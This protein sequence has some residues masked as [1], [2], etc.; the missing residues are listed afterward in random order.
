[1]VQMLL[2]V[3]DT[4]CLVSYFCEVLFAIGTILCLIKC[5]ENANYMFITAVKNSSLASEY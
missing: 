1:M 4:L 3:W 5:L 2:A